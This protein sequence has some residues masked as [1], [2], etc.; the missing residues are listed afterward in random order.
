MSTSLIVLI[1]LILLA[2]VGMLCFVGCAF[3]SDG[4]SGPLFTTYTGTTIL[5]NPSI[6]AYWPLRE[7]EDT[8]PAAN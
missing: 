1:P 6:I 3:D 8:D 4:T 5:L 2:I 7:A